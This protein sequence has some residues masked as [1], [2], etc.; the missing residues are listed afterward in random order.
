MSNLEEQTVSQ[1]ASSFAEILSQFE[2]SH[3]QESGPKKGTVV[4][5]SS[6][7]VFV[8]VGLKTE[9]ILPA[10]QFRD[11]AGNLGIQVGDVAVVTITGRN[12]EGY[13]TLSK[14]KVEKPK[15][16][17]SL[18]AA[19]AERRVIGGVVS[20]VVKGGLSVDVGVR[21]FMPA[22]RSGA[23]DAAELEKLV[24]QEIQC[25]IIKLDVADEDVV[26]DRRV[27]LEE[28][29]QRAR[30]AAFEQLKEGAVVRGTVRTLTDFGAFVDLGSVDGL[31][32]VADISWGRVGKPS[33]VLK[34]GDSLEVKILKVDPASRRISLGLKQLSPDPWSLAEEKFKTG[35]RVRGKVTRVVDFGAFVELEPGLEGLI[36]LAD[37]TWSRKVRKP[38]DV[39]KPGELVEAVVTGVSAAGKRIGLSLKQALGDP[40]DEVVARLPVGATAEGPIVSLADFGAFLEL[41]EGVEGMIH[42]GDISR[43]K[44]IK[45]PREVLTV[46]QRVRAQVLEVDRAKRRIRLGIKQLEPTSIDEYIAEHKTGDKVSGRLV[47]LSQKRAKVELGEGVV[48]ICR[49]P[50]EAKA[51]T[52]AEKSEAKADLAA[53]TAMLSDK[54][55]RGGGSAA[56]SGQEPVRAG[57][58]RSFRI[59]LLDPGSKTIELELAD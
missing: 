31:L 28:E 33:E 4:A 34:E 38:S 42:I 59:S 9:G 16:W 2:E 21:A 7:S 10:D 17:S 6:E 3:R 11:E 19:F 14:L 37:M 58:I 35:D 26:V 49:L 52:S 46:G 18:E 15:D 27:V 8:D 30:Q 56:G 54:W 41:A 5:V 55:K 29:E 32:H 40:W 22:S 57:Q 24:G 39:V 50:V 51:G 43:E 12:S 1:E 45:H 48:A 53:L 44:R 36:R 23:K 47:E 20:G 13:Y 25:R